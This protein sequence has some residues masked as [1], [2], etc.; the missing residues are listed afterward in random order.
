MDE[1]RQGLAEIRWTQLRS[2]WGYWRAFR[3]FN[4]WRPQREQHR[5]RLTDD[6]ARMTQQAKLTTHERTEIVRKAQIRLNSWRDVL[7]RY[8]PQARQII[9]KLVHGR[10]STTPEPRNGVS[11]FRV[12]GSGSYL[13][14]F[15]ET[16]ISTVPQAVASPTGFEPVFWP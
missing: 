4:G 13:K 11:G 16:H 14:F 2:L 9:S 3:W 1:I 5:S 12:T 10:L 8:I 6:L 7:R 15:E